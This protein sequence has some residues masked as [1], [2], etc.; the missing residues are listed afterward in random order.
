[1]LWPATRL[2]DIER[3]AVEVSTMQFGDRLVRISRAGHLH[4]GK[5]ARLARITVGHDTYA[6]NWT[7]SCE[8]L[9]Q[10]VFT[11]LVFK[12]SNENVLHVDAL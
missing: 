6:I 11:G 8:Q 9:A 5:P 10:F 4:E 7:I 3:A 2:I 1:V 12:I